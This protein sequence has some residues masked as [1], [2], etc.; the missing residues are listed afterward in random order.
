MT[1]YQN[2]NTTLRRA[3]GATKAA[4]GTVARARRESAAS[5]GAANR[6]DYMVDDHDPLDARQALETANLMMSQI[7]KG[8]AA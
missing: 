1:G 8:V 3:R 6:T 7:G 4:A 5:E 2:M